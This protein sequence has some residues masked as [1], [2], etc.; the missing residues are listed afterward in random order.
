M[1]FFYLLEQNFEKSRYLIVFL[2]ALTRPLW[3]K[4][5]T[6]NT[7]RRCCHTYFIKRAATAQQVGHYSFISLNFFAFFSGNSTILNKAPHSSA[8]NR[9]LNNQKSG[10]A[11]ISRPTPSAARHHG[12]MQE[13]CG[14]LFK[15]SESLFP[16]VVKAKYVQ[17]AA[18]QGFYTGTQSRQTRDRDG[19]C[20]PIPPLRKILY[21]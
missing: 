8:H 3:G 9:H 10:K 15:C 18:E 13:K 20:A 6:L 12:N 16:A 11:Q 21:L 7:R 5:F 1:I 19:A 2:K 14:G 4:A 17:Q